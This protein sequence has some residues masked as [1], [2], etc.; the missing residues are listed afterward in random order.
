MPLD[1]VLGWDLERQE[2]TAD[3]QLTVCVHRVQHYYLT[4]ARQLMRINATSKSPVVN[5]FGET[6]AGATTIRAFGREDTFKRKNEEHVNSNAAPFFH[7]ISANEWLTQRLDF[8]C[9]CLLCSCALV[10]VLLPS[11]TVEPGKNLVSYSLYSCKLKC[12]VVLES[13]APTSQV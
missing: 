10:M 1:P 5:H 4:S 2:L 13:T 7:T 3:N 6:I 8:L 11:G 12:P 9:T